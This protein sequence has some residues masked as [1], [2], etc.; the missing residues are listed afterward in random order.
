MEECSSIFDVD[1]V[2]LEQ[3]YS[4]SRGSFMNDKKNILLLLI[5]S[6]RL[7][8]TS[9]TYTQMKNSSVDSD[10]LYTILW[11]TR[12]LSNSL[13]NY[14]P[15]MPHTVAVFFGI[16]IDIL[17][18]L[19]YTP[20][21]ISQLIYTLILHNTLMSYT[22]ALPTHNSIQ[23]DNDIQDKIDMNTLIHTHIQQPLSLQHQIQNGLYI[24]F[25]IYIY[26]YTYTYA[27]TYTYTCPHA[28]FMH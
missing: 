11:F 19:G 5:N 18:W 24:Y 21:Y 2:L 27:Y 9:T 28:L 4:S 23:I 10:N 3:E 17:H 1:C 15:Y 14:H 22:H 8:L 16:Y 6:I 25:Y 12:L 20:S 7:L 13:L 26:T